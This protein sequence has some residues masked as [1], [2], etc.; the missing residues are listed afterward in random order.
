MK[1]KNKIIILILVILS[2]AISFYLYNK[3]KSI[4]IEKESYDL[5][6]NEELKDVNFCGKNY[7]TKQISI[8]E[9]N[10]I[11]RISEISNYNYHNDNFPKPTSNDEVYSG[12]SDTSKNTRYS[13]RPN[14]IVKMFCLELEKENLNREISFSVLRETEVNYSFSIGKIGVSVSKNSNIKSFEINLNIEDPSGMGGSYLI[15]M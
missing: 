12:M 3:N 4:Q 10:I 15:S 11:Q 6:I 5:T 13:F 8:N 2:L 1:T 9:I 7:K 14:A